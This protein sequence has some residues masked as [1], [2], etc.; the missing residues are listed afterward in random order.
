MRDFFDTFYNRRNEF[1]DQ[2]F[3]KGK[4]KINV[5]LSGS[6]LTAI[7]STNFLAAMDNIL[8]RDPLDVKADLFIKIED[9]TIKVCIQIH[10]LQAQTD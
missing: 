6:Q 5:A 10:L 3:S 8:K 1:T 4:G 2:F 7:V 9:I